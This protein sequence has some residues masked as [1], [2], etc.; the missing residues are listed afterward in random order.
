[1]D[2]PRDPIFF[3]KKLVSILPEPFISPEGLLPAQISAKEL[4]AID[5]FLYTMTQLA[6]LAVIV[7]LLLPLLHLQTLPM[8]LFA[9]ANVVNL[10]R[11]ITGF[12]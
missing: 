10:F 12:F 8:L 1:V 9:I 3:Q 7:G 11:V 4:A 2:I 6:Q 5:L